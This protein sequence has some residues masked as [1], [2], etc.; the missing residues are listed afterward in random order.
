MEEDNSGRLSVME[1]RGLG[2]ELCNMNSFLNPDLDCG[3]VCGGPLIQKTIF[4]RSL[5]AQDPIASYERVISLPGSRVLTFSISIA[6]RQC[7]PNAE[8][9]LASQ[10]DLKLQTRAPAVGYFH[11]YFS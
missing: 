5:L 7:L 8:G 1:G 4:C 9:T 10:A 6:E 2:A 3:T 11:D